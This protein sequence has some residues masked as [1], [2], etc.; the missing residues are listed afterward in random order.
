[1]GRY[2]YPCAKCGTI[3]TEKTHSTQSDAPEHKLCAACE[4][5]ARKELQEKGEL[6]DDLET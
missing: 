5:A 1:M 3:L 4:E 2:Q 6:T